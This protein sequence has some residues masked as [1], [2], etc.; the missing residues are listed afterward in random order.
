MSEFDQQGQKVEQQHNAGGNIHIGIDPTAIVKILIDSQQ[1]Q[2]SAKDAQL[3]SMADLV[4]S[5]TEAVNAISQSGAPQTDIK[6]ALR[7]LE[8]GDTAKA[9]A[10]FSEIVERKVAEGKAA[11]Q[12]AAAAAQ[13]LGALAY[14]N[15]PLEAL[16]H[17]RRATDSPDWPEK[18]NRLYSPAIASLAAG[19]TLLY[20]AARTS[21][22]PAFV[23][24]LGEYCSGV[25]VLLQPLCLGT[26]E[27]DVL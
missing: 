23:S 12:E 20:N 10:I 4:K 21:S 24:T 17:Y 19:L 1:A 22:L 18:H 9:K 11:N 26:S 14:L 8:T 27:I 3:Q 7:E 6:A 5:L 13:H 2:L 25:W 16:Q 15:D